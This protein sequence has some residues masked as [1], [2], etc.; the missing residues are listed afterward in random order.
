VRTLTVGNGYRASLSGLGRNRGFE[1]LSQKRITKK[2]REVL[3]QKY[4]L[5]N[6][7]VSCAA[8]LTTHGWQGSCK[9][10]SE[11]FRYKISA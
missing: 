6:V 9:I 8:S 3:R 5:P 7:E 1:E 4:G 2:V 11:E 10:Y